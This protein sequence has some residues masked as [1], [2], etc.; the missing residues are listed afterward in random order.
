ARPA[1]PPLPLNRHPS[2]GTA[3]LMRPRR[4]YHVRFT[5]PLLALLLACA[6]VGSASARAHERAAAPATLRSLRSLVDHYRS[7]T[8]TYERA[9]HRRRTPTSYSERRSVDGPYL[10]WSLARWTRRAESARRAAVGRIERRLS[11]RLP[12]APRLH[13]RLWR[14]LS[15]SRR[16]ALSL[17]RIY[18]GNVSRSFALATRHSGG[19]T[20]R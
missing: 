3:D 17:R 13:A 1:A 11:V 14:R 10:R 9:A 15:Y 6:L 5:L 2:P 18:P 8:W 4:T 7:V 19:E 20:L 12:R 16:L